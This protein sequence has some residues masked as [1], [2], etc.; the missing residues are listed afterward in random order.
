MD[1]SEKNHRMISNMICLAKKQEVSWTVLASFL[2]E[3]SSTLAKSKQVIKILLKEMENICANTNSLAMDTLHVFNHQINSE[4]E[5]NPNPNSDM[6]ETLEPNNADYESGSLDASLIANKNEGEVKIDIKGKIQLVK[7]LK[8][9][10][11]TF[12]G[13]DAENKTSNASVDRS[14]GSFENVNR[15][16]KLNHTNKDAKVYLTKKQKLLKCESLLQSK[17]KS[18]VDLVC[19]KCGNQFS[20][21]DNWVL[22]KH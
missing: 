21:L 13:D 11:F 8:D 12:G 9:Q 15:M 14:E 22:L 17:P 1:I 5:D 10:L 6:D 3:T 18:L 16:K 4:L 2:D 20:R 19:T 7:E